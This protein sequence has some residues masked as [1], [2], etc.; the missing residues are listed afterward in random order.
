MNEPK[1]VKPPWGEGIRA[2]AG[3]WSAEPEMDELLKQIYL[4]RKLE[5]RDPFAGDADFMSAQ[6]PM[7]D[8]ERAELERVYQER[9]CG[10]ECDE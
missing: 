6:R 7:S 10:V 8:D 3:A 9:G 1:Q 4:D 5:R 2:S